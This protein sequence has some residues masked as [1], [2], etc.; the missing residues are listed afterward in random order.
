MSHKKS[1]SH[2]LQQNKSS[3][4]Y[5][6]KRMKVESGKNMSWLKLTESLNKAKENAE[7]LVKVKEE[8]E[9]LLSEAKELQN[10]QK[11]ELLSI[12]KE[13]EEASIAERKKKEL[14]HQE[15]VR[16]EEEKRKKEEAERQQQEKER[17]VK[18]LQQAE[19]DCKDQKA[20][21]EK[22]CFTFKLA[23]YLISKYCGPWSGNG[24][25]DSESLDKFDALKC[26]STFG[27]LMPNAVEMMCEVMDMKNAKM[28]VDA[29]AG[30]GKLA[31]QVFLRFPNVQKIVAIELMK[32]R[33]DV[34]VK[35]VREIQKRWPMTFELQESKDGLSVFFS[36]RGQNRVLEMKNMDLFDLPKEEYQKTNVLLLETAISRTSEIRCKLLMNTPI[37]CHVFSYE[38]YEKYGKVDIECRCGKC[39]V[40]FHLGMLKGER[41]M[42]IGCGLTFHTTWSPQTQFAMAKRIA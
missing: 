31:L 11:E 40:G 7:L 13:A 20:S 4:E 23:N 41:F 12:Y 30:R 32:S 6:F 26:H 35:A 2:A 10:K 15:L 22:G 9:R 28:F 33:Y 34:G 37:G 14:I 39:N 3:D 17:I 29:G 36:F 18:E 5:R 16:K 24:E 38:S 1:Y 27:E 25:V 21:D 42:Q 19:L 8:K